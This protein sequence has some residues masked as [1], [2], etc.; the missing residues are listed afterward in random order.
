MYSYTC[1]Y[2]ILPTPPARM[3]QPMQSE[4]RQMNSFPAIRC[5]CST[6]EH[7]IRRIRRH[8]PSKQQQDIA[9]PSVNHSFTVSRTSV[10]NQ[11]DILGPSGPQNPH[12]HSL[13]AM[14][15][16]RRRALASAQGLFNTI[17]SNPLRQRTEFRKF[18][19]Q[20]NSTTLPT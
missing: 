3:F 1:N 12:K 19:D 8:F 14:S 2:Y 7:P 20:P 10:H 16:R 9:N 4:H 17:F 6:L 15:R 13:L 5:C 11:P 18:R